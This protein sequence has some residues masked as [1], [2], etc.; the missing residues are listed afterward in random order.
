MLGLCLV[1]WVS[2]STTDLFSYVGT[3]LCLASGLE[4]RLKCL[5]AFNSNRAGSNAGSTCGPKKSSFLR[6]L[7]QQKVA[8]SRNQYVA[9][10]KGSFFFFP[11]G[12]LVILVEKP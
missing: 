6:N 12:V 1:S 5:E 3:Y 9:P 10:S 7:S 2:H 4:T 11:S 8:V